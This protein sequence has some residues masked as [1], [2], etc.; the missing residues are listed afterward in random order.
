MVIEKR[1]LAEWAGGVFAGMRL[2]EAW[3][4]AESRMPPHAHATASVTACELE[5]ASEPSARCA[6]QKLTGLKA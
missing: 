4:G 6:N 1:L 5:A 3:Y 2:S